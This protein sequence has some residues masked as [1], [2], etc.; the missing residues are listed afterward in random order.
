MAEFCRQCA[1]KYDIGGYSKAPEKGL[2]MIEL[3]EGCGWTEVDDEGWCL[4]HE[5]HLEGREPT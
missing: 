4:D 1:E 3:C 5:Y 2:A